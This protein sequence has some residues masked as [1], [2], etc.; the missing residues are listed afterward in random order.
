MKNKFNFFR[1]L[2]LLYMA[3]FLCTI[4][5]A[6][7]DWKP[8]FNGKN[9]SNWEVKNGTA[10][11]HIVN[12]A[13]VGTSKT[14]TPN[15]FLCTKKMYSDF[16]LELE[17][18]VAPGLNSGIQFRSNSFKDYK[19][20]RVHG[21]QSE[22]DTSKRAW[23][24]GIYDEGR[25]GWVYPLTINPKGSAAFNNGE[26]NKVR[27]EAIG[28]TIKTFI[29]GIQCTNLVDEMTSEG[30]I[31]LQVH[32]IRDESQQG[33]T[34]Q[35]KN[36]KIITEN[37]D[38]YATESHPYARQVSYLKN[39]LTKEEK[40]KGWRLLWDGKTS[41]GWKSAKSAEFPEKG[42]TIENG[43]L[44]VMESGGGESRNGGDIVTKNKFGNFELEV[45]FRYTPG[46]NS[47]IKYFVDTSL[48]QGAGS[49]IG[50]EFQILDDELHPDAK[51]GIQ[52]N[53][54]LA[55]LYDLIRSES[56]QEPRTERRSAGANAWHRA[57]IIVNGGHVEHWLNNMKVV[58]YDRYSQM[59]KYLVYYSKYAKYPGFGTAAEGR[60]LLQDHGN[61]VHF[62]NIKIREL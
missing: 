2:L 17:V 41:K 43:M 53:R 28:N 49:S 25:R 8:L 56:L 36:I 22:L 50:C 29:N 10:E 59:F 58:E 55:S 1:E 33:K 5:M 32:S 12:N 39:S 45:D 19:N 61:T 52:S 60:I 46:A 42:W 20:G 11:Y 13:I 44:T 37:L 14:G 7:S 23:T 31:A 51:K 38:R 57:R 21:Y 30:F 18:L 15:T 40:R 16:I 62:K 9:L 48:N 4:T 47:G 34:I 54:T 24:G 3:L 6:Q 35:W 26:W 27:I